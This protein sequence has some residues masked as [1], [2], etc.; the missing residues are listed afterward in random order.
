MS[1]NIRGFGFALAKLEIPARGVCDN[2]YS[3]NRVRTV[4][5][6]NARVPGDK[7]VLSHPHLV[8]QNIPAVLLAYRH[9]HLHKPDAGWR[10]GKLLCVT[11][12]RSLFVGFL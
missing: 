6:H 2:A 11:C 1:P 10:K 4:G 9:G 7:R 3:A 5:L 12:L 8:I